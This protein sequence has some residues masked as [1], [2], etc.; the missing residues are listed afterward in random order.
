MGDEWIVLLEAERAPRA[1]P[2]DRLDVGRLR[3]A[4]DGGQGASALW[5][6]DRYV[7]QVRVTAPTPIDAL[8]DVVARWQEVVQRLS[9][10]LWNLVRTEILTPEELEREHEQTTTAAGLPFRAEAYELLAE[11]H[12]MSEELLHSALSDPQTG[13]AGREVFEHRLQTRFD[14]AAT[15]RILAVVLIEVEPGRRRRRA[16]HAGADDLSITLATRLAAVLRREDILARVGSNEYAV[17]LSETNTEAAALGVSARL[18]D[19]VRA[20]LTL[21]GRPLTLSASAGVA[22][23]EPMDTPT[24]LLARATTAL[25]AARVAGGGAVARG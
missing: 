7:V 1:G 10:P 2:I 6:S 13:L 4:M 18:L 9:I 8:H 25:A 19:A 15:R 12:A 5:C 17:L 23:S 20:P 22:V 16:C 24:T 11:D 21:R 14:D 3:D